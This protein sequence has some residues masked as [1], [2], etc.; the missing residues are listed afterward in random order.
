MKIRSLILQM[1]LISISLM[2]APVLLN[3]QILTIADKTDAYGIT[4][5]YCKGSQDLEPEL[6]RDANVEGYGVNIKYRGTSFGHRNTVVE[7][8]DTVGYK[9]D[10]ATGTAI[11]QPGKKLIIEEVPI[12]RFSF[13]VGY[14]EYSGFESPLDSLQADFDLS[15]PYAGAWFSFPIDENG[16]VSAVLGYTS[17]VLT[18]AKVQALYGVD[19]AAVSFDIPT[20]V[21][22]EI[23]FGLSWRV[24][25]RLS[26]F[27]EI[28]QK[29]LNVKNIS[30]TPAGEAKSGE[31]IQRDLGGN[32]DLGFQSLKVGM[33]ISF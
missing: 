2:E 23:N 24:I 33:S 15:G 11:K 14:L 25:R 4:A 5:W 22:H 6:N 29:W 17:A 19:S 30:Y 32:M 21:S 26:L 12:V 20:T 8:E 7:L 16:V 31:L 28:N 9:L 18:V 1:T 10:P 27:A 13:G 3:A